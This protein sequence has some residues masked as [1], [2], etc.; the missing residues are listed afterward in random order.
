MT[1]PRS[2]ILNDLSFLNDML[3]HP[4]V[5]R[6]NKFRHVYLSKSVVSSNV[7]FDIRSLVFAHSACEYTRLLEHVLSKD[8]FLIFLVFK[9][10]DRGVFISARNVA[11]IEQD[12]PPV[13][14][15]A[16]HKALHCD[17]LAFHAKKKQVYVIVICDNSM[18]VRQCRTHALRVAR[19]LTNIK[20]LSSTVFPFVLTVYSFD[21][22]S[23]MRL[24]PVLETKVLRKKPRNNNTRRSRAATA[25]S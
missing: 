9:L 15:E 12:R 5:F 17:V 23:G 2:K 6:P 25:M 7:F 1:P 11:V 10:L 4:F 13:E 24:C 18:H 16:V 14:L 19:S 3:H 22:T 20:P 21:R 8:D